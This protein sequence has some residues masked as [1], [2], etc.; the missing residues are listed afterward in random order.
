MGCERGRRATDRRAGIPGCQLIFSPSASRAPCRFLPSDLPKNLKESFMRRSLRRLLASLVAPAAMAACSEAVK[1][2]PEPG[3]VRIAATFPQSGYLS[4]DGAKMRDGYVLAV[5]MLNEQGG[6]DGRDV[7]LVL[8]DDGSDPAAAARIYGEFVADSAVDALLGPYSSVVAEAVLPVVEAASRPLIVGLAASSE[9][10]D[11]RN[12][13]W[14]VQMLNSAATFLHG[15]VVLAARGGARTAAL[16]WED[17][18][19]P[20]SVAAG[21]RES[22]AQAGLRLVLDQSYSP[23][24]ADHAALASAAKRSGA[25]VFLGGGYLRD[26]IGLVRAADAAGYRPQLIS[27]ALGPADPGFAAEVGD[28]ARCVT[29]NTPWLPS[30]QTTGTLAVSETFVA[31]F[32][33]K[34][35]RE[36]G[37]H[38]AA[39]FGA[40]ELLAAGLAEALTPVGVDH[41]ALRDFLFAAKTKT[42][43]GAYGVA[44]LGAASA[45]RQQALEGLQVQWQDDGRGGLVQRVVHPSP[46]A[47][48]ELCFSRTPGPIRVAA[49]YPETG[50]LSADGTKMRAGYALGVEMLNE[51]GGIGGRLVELVTLDDRSNPQLAASRYRQFVADSSIDALLGPYASSVT[52]SVLPVTE[53]ASKPLIAAMAAS[54]SLWTGRGR[55]W[56]VQMLNPAHTYL[57]GSVD[58]AAAAGAQTVA[59]VWENSS[60]PSAVAQ[61]VR[62]AAQA[63]GLR[64]VL[65]RSYPVGGAD[66]AALVEAAKQSGADLFIGGGY[67]HDAIELT[68]AAAAAEYAPKLASWS[69]GPADPRFAQEVGELARCVAG[70][71]PWIPSVRTR[72][73]ISD[74]ETFAR[75]FQEA[76]G[77]P[78]GYHAAG[79]F[80]AVELLSAGLEA[81]LAP[82]GELDE[83]AMRDFVFSA[84]TQTVLGPFRVAPLGSADAGSQQ[85]LVGLQVQWQDDGQGGLEQRIIHPAAM[86]NAEPCFSR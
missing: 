73:A 11:G 13:R 38:E 12:R 1:P 60:F 81:S 82:D 71:A 23:D 64:I 17:S 14:S 5:E 47:N 84:N 54:T 8:R 7:E 65:D 25:D 18:R 31:R 28:L 63:A 10:W 79:G 34:H 6:I 66:H 49:S 4:T 51:R 36:P 20:A 56:S 58:V 2:L 70:N 72:G 57:Q 30:I 86:A 50:R 37:Y 85:A 29:G 44:P 69:I 32:R 53:A 16:V 24:Q 42:V 3:D 80:G 75:R 52:E 59:L 78:P 33:Q 9:L 22:A 77:G 15:S 26:A 19:F 62:S 68:K 76:H 27:L 83:A 43:L 61:G 46:A 39:A 40:V 48:A 35:G 74:S 55:R 45:G 21:V 67:L 41:A